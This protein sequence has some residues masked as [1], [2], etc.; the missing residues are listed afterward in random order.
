MRALSSGMALFSE[1]ERNGLGLKKTAFC[2]LWQPDGAIDDDLRTVILRITDSSVSSALCST[3][4]Y[5]ELP[6]IRTL[7]SAIFAAM[8]RA[9]NTAPNTAPARKQTAPIIM[10]CPYSALMGTF[11]HPFG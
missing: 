1:S 8:Q 2:L 4:S 10:F 3:R 11:P 9:S 5:R 6:P 7:S